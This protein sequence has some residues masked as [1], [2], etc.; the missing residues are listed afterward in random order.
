MLKISS[1]SKLLSREDA[2]Y[3]TFISIF[4]FPIFCGIQTITF[5]VQKML[6]LWSEYI[7][8]ERSKSK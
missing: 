7:V 6:D 4:I 8:E 1:S 3:C 2:A 5:R